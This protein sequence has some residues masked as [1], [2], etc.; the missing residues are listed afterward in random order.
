MQLMDLPMSEKKIVKL[1]LFFS[2]MSQVL[3]LTNYNGIYWDDWVL[4]SH[5]SETINNMFL[6]AAGYSGWYATFL[7]VVLLKVG[8]FSYRLIFVIM[9]VAL[10][11][12]LYKIL[13]EFKWL[14]KL[15]KLFICL[16]VSFIPYFEVGHYLINLPYTLNYC[17]F[18]FA[19]YLYTVWKNDL[20]RVQCFIILTIFFI[21]FLINSLVSYYAI[22]LLYLFWLGYKNNESFWYNVKIY[23]L[24]NYLFLVLPLFFAGIKFYFFVPNG[25]YVGYNNIG[26]NGDFFINLHSQVVKL[27]SINIIELYS[28]AYDL[29]VGFWWLIFPL[30]L[31]GVFFINVDVNKTPIKLYIAFSLL[32]FLFFILG[33][34]PY[35]VVDK[36]PVMSGPN[37]RFQLLLPLGLS[38]F[39]YSTLSIVF[40]WVSNKIKELILI[41]ILILFFILKVDSVVKYQLD[42][43]YQQAI[44]EEFK[45]ND[46]I[47][48]NTTFSYTVHAPNSIIQPIS[49]YAINGLSR[50]AFGNDS[51]LIAYSASES[52][53][54]GLTKYVNY[55]QYNF[56]SWERSKTIHFTIV[57]SDAYPIG[58]HGYE[59]FI[60]VMTMRY[61]EIFDN[62]KYRSGLNKLIKLKFE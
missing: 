10:S 52:D 42:W 28:Q 23:F 43:F 15:D 2:F 8:I 6:M 46:N 50:V 34:F 45:N 59:K 30:S 17:L 60:Y 41:I 37:S 16:L 25:L 36:M 40:Y 44:V 38:L 19:F 12:F 58:P 33:A 14:S 31:F 24:S 62:E 3:V 48:R 55:K 21:S 49:F 9:N 22:F 26:L 56:S 7:H 11:Y 29:F 57:K 47:K 61:L 54:D 39:I 51:K 1:V 35:I 27:I 4:F 32:G 13:S 18:F 5:S 20:N 53:I